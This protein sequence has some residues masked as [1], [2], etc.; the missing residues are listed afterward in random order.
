MVTSLQKYG[1]QILIINS[2]KIQH[3][4]LKNN[5]AINNFAGTNIKTLSKH[6]QFIYFKTQINKTNSR[7]H[8]LLCPAR[9]NLPGGAGSRGNNSTLRF[10]ENL[11]PHRGKI[12]RDP[13]RQVETKPC[14]SIIS[15]GARVRTSFTWGAGVREGGA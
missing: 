14:G 7:V 10:D 6:L 13:K 5:K 4:K 8:E 12:A 1:K 9:W 11:L 3:S 15:R 2:V